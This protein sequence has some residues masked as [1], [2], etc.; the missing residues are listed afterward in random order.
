MAKQGTRRPRIVVTSTNLPKLRA[1]ANLS[2][3]QLARR[4]GVS[5]ASIR[6]LESGGELDER[7]LSRIRE[8]IRPLLTSGE[9]HTN[10]PASVPRLSRTHPDSWTELP[11]AGGVL[12]I[13]DDSARPVFVGS[14]GNL[15]DV[16][17]RNRRKSWFSR[18]LVGTIGYAE[19]EDDRLCAQVTALLKETC[20]ST[21]LLTDQMQV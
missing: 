16:V 12:V 3:S 13:F 21:I 9:V 8:A 17:G 1:R 7:S 18:P 15:R 2:I 6:H 20:K 19:I 11:K 5:G 4:S 14:A 10:V